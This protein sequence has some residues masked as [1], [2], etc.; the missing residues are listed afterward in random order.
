MLFT[1]A[2]VSSRRRHVCASEDV[3]AVPTDDRLR[4][5]L[6]LTSTPD[7]DRGVTRGINMDRMDTDTSTGQRIVVVST[8]DHRLLVPMVRRGRNSGRNL[9]ACCNVGAGQQPAE[10]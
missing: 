4:C 8:L 2:S 7:I 1:R 5:S 6:R 3:Q 10:S 9:V